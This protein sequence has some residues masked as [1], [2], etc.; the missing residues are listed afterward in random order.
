MDNDIRDALAW[1]AMSD[2]VDVE[3]LAELVPTETDFLRDHE[4]KTWRV[5]KPDEAEQLRC[6]ILALGRERDEAERLA[7]EMW[8]ALQGVHARAQ[9]GRRMK[10]YL[11]R[12]GMLPGEGESDAP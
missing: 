11:E 5:I 12:A 8:G 6:D 1:L 9:F 10:P 2:R 4:R 3:A 7:L